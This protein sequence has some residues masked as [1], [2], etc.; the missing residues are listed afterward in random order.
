MT[1]G[2]END[3]YSFYHSEATRFLGRNDQS[4]ERDTV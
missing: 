3:A 1:F 2:R 4:L